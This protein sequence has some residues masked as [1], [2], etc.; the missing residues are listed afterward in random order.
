[1]SNMTDVCS[2][3]GN[4]C[5][6][7]GPEVT[8]TFVVVRVANFIVLCIVF[9]RPLFVTSSFFPQTIVLFVL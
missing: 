2:G 9:C 3:A 7:R 8:P 6:S 1:M 4:A 5:S